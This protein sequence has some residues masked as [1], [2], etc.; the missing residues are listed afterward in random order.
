MLGPSIIFLNLGVPPQHYSMDWCW[1]TQNVLPYEES[2]VVGWPL[3]PYICKAMHTFQAIC[4]RHFF[5]LG[6]RNVLRSSSSGHF[7]VFHRN[8]PSGS[9]HIP[10][11]SL[12]SFC[13]FSNNLSAYLVKNL[14]PVL[15]FNN[16]KHLKLFYIFSN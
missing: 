15:V 11:D 1:P 6:M 16:R 10:I 13:N 7:W 8:V 14:K 3:N 5:M 12:S 2:P 9:T 4:A